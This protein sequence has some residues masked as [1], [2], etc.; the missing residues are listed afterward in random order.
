MQEGSFTWGR[1][2][3]QSHTVEKRVD[4][5]WVVVL[6]SAALLLFTIN[7]GG[8]ALRDWDEGTVAQVAREIWGVLKLVRG[9]GFTRR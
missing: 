2:E 8:L 9:I 5:V 4:G 1:L 6:L 3:K 7:L